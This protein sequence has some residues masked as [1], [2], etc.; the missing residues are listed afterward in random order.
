MLKSISRQILEVTHTD[1]P[2]FERAFFVVRHDCADQSDDNLVDE[3]QLLL[4][5]QHPYSGILRSHLK[6]RLF[7]L[8]AFLIGGAAGAAVAVCLCKF[9]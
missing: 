4:H 6:T 8:F 7:R 2:Y 1:H 9:I 3:A 5:R